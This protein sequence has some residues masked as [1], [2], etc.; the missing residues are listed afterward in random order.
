MCYPWQIGCMVKGAANSAVQSFVNALA[1]GLIKQTEFVSSFWMKLPSPTVAHGGGSSWTEVASLAQLHGDLAVYTGFFAFLSFVIA[2]GRIA[3]TQQAQGA[4]NIVRQ[5]AAV[6]AGTLA[7][8][9][10]T[11]LLIMAGDA[12]STWELGRASGGDPSTGLKQLIEFGIGHPNNALGMWLVLFL[13]EL[14]ASLAQCVYMLVRGAA[15]I[16]LL[17]IVPPTAAGSASEEGWVRFKR[18]CMLILGFVLYKPVAAIIYSAGIRLMSQYG[19][20]PS[21]KDGNVQNAMYGL[22]VMIMAGIALPAFI[23]FISPAAA[24]GSSNA[25]SGGAALG[26]IAAGAAVVAMGAGGGGAATAGAGNGLGSSGAGQAGGRA[27]FVDQQSSTPPGG[28]TAQPSP[29]ASTTVPG[30]G[31]EDATQPIQTGG[32]TPTGGERGSDDTQPIPTRGSG[33]SSASTDSQPTQ[34]VSSSTGGGSRGATPQPVPDSGA[35]GAPAGSSGGGSQG[36]VNGA[37]QSVQSVVS[38]A[39]ADPEEPDVPGGARS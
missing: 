16:V 14:I 36:L 22:T 28:Q 9:A 5:V 15:L 32:A 19:D 37:S 24:A 33:Q 1:D 12:F 13:I 27:G 35:S 25:F 39:S 18:L 20:G 30:T 10:V 11:Q 21:S 38:A 31:G 2:L 8:T 29:G 17:T 4:H 26:A 7:I 23:K 3:M 34:P 6:G